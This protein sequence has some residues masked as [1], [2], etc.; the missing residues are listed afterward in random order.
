MGTFLSGYCCPPTNG[1]EFEGK[2]AESLKNETLRYLLLKAALDRDR[3]QVAAQEKVAWNGNEPPLTA[4]D[5]R[6]TF[7]L[8]PLLGAF[9]LDIVHGKIAAARW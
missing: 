5:L 4:N 9:D 2:A 7:C 1:P 3:N 6:G 8:P